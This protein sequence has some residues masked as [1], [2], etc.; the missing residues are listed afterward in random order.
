MLRV[1]FWG[2]RM[3]AVEFFRNRIVAM[4][5]L[6]YVL[7]APAT[8]LQWSQIE[9]AIAAKVSKLHVR[10][11]RIRGKTSPNLG[12]R[13]INLGWYFDFDFCRTD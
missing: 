3:Q 6:Q 5:I 9:T 2:F 7:A 10:S 12:C 4:R 8:R 13:S 11:R 1:I